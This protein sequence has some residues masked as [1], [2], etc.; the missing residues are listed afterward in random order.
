MKAA[1]LEVEHMYRQGN[2]Q[3]ID[4]ERLVVEL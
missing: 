3:L 1:S 4:S 2:V